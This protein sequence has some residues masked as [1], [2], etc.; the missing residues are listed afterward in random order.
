VLLQCRNT[1]FDNFD[2]LDKAL[3]DLL[4]EECKGCHKEYT[5]LRMTL[6]LL[7]LKASNGWSNNSFFGSLRIAK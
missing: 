3:R 7:K 2:T 4:Y 1:C 6:V 5:V